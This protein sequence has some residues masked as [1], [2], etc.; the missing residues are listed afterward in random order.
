MKAKFITTLL[1]PLLGLV[2]FMNG[3]ATASKLPTNADEKYQE[4]DGLVVGVDPMTD[5]D[6]VKC[7]FGENLLAKGV[8]P[9]KLRARNFNTNASFIVAREKIQILCESTNS[10]H[11]S[12]Q[13]SA[14]KDFS[15][16][17]RSQLL[18]EAAAH[19]T[20]IFLAELMSDREGPVID[21]KREYNLSSKEFYT[22]TL[23]PG[24]KAEGILFF[25]FQKGASP[26]GIYHFI[27]QLKNTATGVVTPFDFTL[28]LNL[29]NLNSHDFSLRP[30]LF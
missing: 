14:G 19:G 5:K 9:I 12:R 11:S 16:V 15:V 28:D 22:R 27:A 13:A 21:R 24:Q 18:A 25:R 26:S 10:I 23:G 3:C 29:K 20:L 30:R 1:L 4:I 7:N 8:L 2:W 6:E 17:P